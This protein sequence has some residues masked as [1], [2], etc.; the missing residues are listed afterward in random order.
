MTIRFP[1]FRVSLAISAEVFITI[2][3][4]CNYNS[5]TRILYIRFVKLLVPRYAIRVSVRINRILLNYT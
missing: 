1:Y 2:T 5:V 3:Y 4:F